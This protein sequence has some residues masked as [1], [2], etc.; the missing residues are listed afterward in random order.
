MKQTAF[1]LL[2]LLACGPLAAAQR[3][4]KKPAVSCCAGQVTAKPEDKPPLPEAQPTAKMV[5]YAA[6]DVVSRY[7]SFGVPQKQASPCPP[8]FEHRKLPLS[9]E[10]VSSP[11]STRR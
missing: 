1:V 10:S 8:I 7:K 11:R 4:V 3:P 2:V 5:Q 9:E 6:N